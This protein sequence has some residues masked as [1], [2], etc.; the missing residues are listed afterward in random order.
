MIP[1]ELLTQIL[2]NLVV[3]LVGIIV[4]MLVQKGFFMPYLRVRMSFGKFVLIKI[5]AINRDYF[6]KGEIIEGFLVWKTKTGARRVAVK[7]K[8][9]FY[10]ALACS[11]IDVD[12]EKNSICYPDYSVVSGFDAEKYDNLYKRTLYRPSVEDAKTKIIIILVIIAILFSGISG[13]LS[14][15]GYQNTQQIFGQLASMQ[16]GAVVPT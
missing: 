1:N 9:A 11:W 16:A 12:D 6:K 2:N 14:Y 5:R 13:Y 3:M 7:D 8:N 10:R 15:V 4:I